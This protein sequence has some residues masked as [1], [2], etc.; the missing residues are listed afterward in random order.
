MLLP[1]FFFSLTSVFCILQQLLL[2]VPP[3]NKIN[4]LDATFYSARVNIQAHTHILMHLEML[5][6]KMA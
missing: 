1:S 2:L 3:S 4:Q 5:E 6:F